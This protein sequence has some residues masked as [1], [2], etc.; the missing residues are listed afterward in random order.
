MVVLSSYVRWGD[1]LIGA[2]LIG[3]VLIGA[4]PPFGARVPRVG[5]TR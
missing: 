1:V 3:A 2:V 4:V 5:V